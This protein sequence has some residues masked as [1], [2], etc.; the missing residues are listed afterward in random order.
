MMQR[1]IKTIVLT[2]AFSGQ[3]LAEDKKEV[4]AYQGAFNFE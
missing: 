4:T 2:V 1:I 3:L